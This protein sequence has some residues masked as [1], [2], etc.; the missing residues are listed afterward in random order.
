MK[1][2]PTCRLTRRNRFR[3]RTPAHLYNPAII[4][5]SAP[6]LGA[7]LDETAN[8]LCNSAKAPRMLFLLHLVNEALDDAADDDQD[9]DG[10]DNRNSPFR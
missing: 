8:P 9:D 4:R 6:I 7:L 5:K 1:A 2:F 3:G 10:D